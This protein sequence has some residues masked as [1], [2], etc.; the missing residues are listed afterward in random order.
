MLTGHLKPPRSGPQS[1][2]VSDPAQDL[3]SRHHH[4]CFVCG[5]DRSNSLAMKFCLQPDDSVANLYTFRREFEGYN[6][7]VH[8]G[9]IA[10]ALDGAM[11]NW[12]F[13]HGHSAVTAELKIRYLH[14]VETQVPALVQARF[15]EGSGPLFIMTAELIQQ[16][17]R[18]ATATAKFIANSSSAKITKAGE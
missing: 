8:G 5:A 16:G 15:T 13:I 12:L 2:P 4:E 3:R 9:I 10:A 11:T 17:R 14:P 1:S 18:M 6:G 7:F